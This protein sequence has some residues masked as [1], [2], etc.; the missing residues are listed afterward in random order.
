MAFS[1]NKVNHNDSTPTADEQTRHTC[2][3]KREQDDPRY[4]PSQDKI[5]PIE[6]QKEALRYSLEETQREMVTHAQ[7]FASSVARSESRSEKL[8]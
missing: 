6:V 4:Q 5:D 1:Q 3:P 8:R 7:E 2:I